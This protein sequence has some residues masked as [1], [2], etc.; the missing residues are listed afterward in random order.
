MIPN[1]L[2]KMPVAPFGYKI[3][4]DAASGTIKVVPQ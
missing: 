1:Y 3:N 2:G 4:Y